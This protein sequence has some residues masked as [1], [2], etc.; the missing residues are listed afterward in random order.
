MPKPTQHAVI[1]W[2]PN[3]GDGMREARRLNARFR[4]Y[5]VLRA[6]DKLTTSE[7]SEYMSLIVVGH[8]GEFG[9]ATQ[10]SL[11][12]LLH[13]SD[14][15]WVVLANC[16]SGVATSVGAL[17]DNELWSPAQRLAN[18]LRIKVSGTARALTFDEVGLGL[19]FALTLGEV[20]IRSNPPSAAHLW[21]DYEAQS[22]VD[23]V[24]EGI[25]HL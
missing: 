13:G 16:S 22:E 7:L 25:S 24:A 12:N 15:H 21:R 1:T 23:E 14:C 10:Q 4:N 17:G 8:R 20:L 18:A 11:A 9:D 3:S 5:S 19:A 2:I 6:P